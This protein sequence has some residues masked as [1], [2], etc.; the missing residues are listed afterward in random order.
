PVEREVFGSWGAELSDDDF[1]Q[2]LAGLGLHCT[3][4]DSPEE[5]W[6]FEFADI[7][8]HA[9]QPGALHHIPISVRSPLVAQLARFLLRHSGTWYRDRWR[10]LMAGR[11]E[12]PN[13]P[14]V[15]A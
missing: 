1:A 8:R 6:R 11:E 13:L 10:E 5:A 3:R 15:D 4:A 7:P 9:R 2:A 14:W 12:S